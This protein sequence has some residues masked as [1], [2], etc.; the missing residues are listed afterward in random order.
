V[1]NAILDAVAAEAAGCTKC[2]LAYQGR[3]Q[4]VFG[5]GNPNADLMFVG[6]GPGAEEDRQG[7]PFVGRSGQLLDRLMAEELGIDRSWCYVANVIK[8]LRYTAMVQLA[9]GSWERIGRLVRRRYDGEVMSVDDGGHLVPRR[10]IGWYESPLAGRRVYRLT[11][12]GAKRNSNGGASTQLT[13]DHEV[14]TEEGWQPVERLRPGTRI[15]TGQ[16]L[17][18]SAFDVICGTLLGDGHLNA[19]SAHLSFSHSMRQE[20][21]AVFKARVLS[22]LDPQLQW[23]TVSA[24]VGGHQHYDVVQVRTPANRALG[25]L[26]SQFYAEGKRVPTWIVERLNPRMLAIWFMDDGHLRLRPPR[27]PSAEIATCSFVDADLDLL[28]EALAR[29]GI[30]ASKRRGRLHFGVAATQRLAETIAPFVPPSMRYKLPPDVAAAAPFEL[31]RFRAGPAQVLYDE[32][33][34]VDVTDRPRTDTTLFCIDVEE[35]HNF[36]TSGGVVHN[37]RPP[38]NRDPLPVEVETCW[39][40]LDRQLELIDPKVVITLGRFA[41]HQ[42]LDTKEGINRLRGRVHHYRGRLIVPTFH[43]AAVLRGGG[44]P[45]AQTRADFIRAKRELVDAGAEP[46]A[47]MGSMESTRNGGR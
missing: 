7:L 28:V 16:G 43:P 20:A 25:V 30:D 36:V 40:Y 46:W 47:S 18:A 44:E 34:V 31:G 26:R 38:G 6:E 45:M 41:A 4:V 12:R 5:M 11:F 17:S 2:P 24:V 1:P 39:P 33:E 15:A 3:T 27:R 32:A 23:T 35:T 42:L 8:C 37:C 21:Y 14:L 29:R 10:V 9:D 22:E 13:G 19:N